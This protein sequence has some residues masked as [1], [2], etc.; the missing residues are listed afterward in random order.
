M[1]IDLNL[2]ELRFCQFMDSL[3][4]CNGSCNI[5]DYFSSRA[6]VP[7]KTIDVYLNV[8]FTIATRNE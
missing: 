2:E 7:N 5:L 8:S 3:D 6:Y 4:K 1:L